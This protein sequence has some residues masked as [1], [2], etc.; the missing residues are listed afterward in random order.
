[1]ALT[2]IIT[3]FGL[4]GAAGL[5]AYIPLLIVGILGKLGVLTLSEP[6]NIL[7]SWPAIIIIAVLLIVEVVVDKV[8]GADHLNDVIQT[9]VRPAAGAVLFA[10]NTG[11]V[12]GMDPTLAL[13]LGLV[14]AL[15]THAVKAAA[16]P[17]VNATTAGLGAPVVSALE[18][19][20][21][22]TTSLVAIFLPPLLVVLVLLI[23]YLYW[24]WRIR[25]KDDADRAKLESA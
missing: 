3:A 6:F 11:V 8:P 10:A 9:I 22:A 15:S 14:M 18:D 19:V 21:S 23:G 25:G 13:G 2:N 4:A 24:R 7:T 16:R 1:M 5:N 20:T 12:Q 17:V